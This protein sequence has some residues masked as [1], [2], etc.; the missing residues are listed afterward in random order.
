MD[1]TKIILEEYAKAKSSKEV[2]E[3]EFELDEEENNL[4][5]VLNC[6]QR[7]SFMDMR[8]CYF[9]LLMECEKEVVNFTLNF[10]KAIFNK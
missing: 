8:K 10:I 9:H 7:K 4:I 2:E 5:E 3:C 1:I 6:E